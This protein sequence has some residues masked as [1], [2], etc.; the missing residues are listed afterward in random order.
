MLKLAER[1]VSMYFNGVSASNNTGWAKLLGSGIDDVKIATRSNVDEPGR[2][3]GVLLCATHCL[4]LP[5]ESRKLFD[6]FRDENNRNNV[7]EPINL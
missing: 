7:C 1:M 3:L 5:I 2:P 6:F 4:W